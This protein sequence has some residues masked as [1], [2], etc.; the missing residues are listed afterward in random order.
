MK[1]NTPANYDNDAPSPQYIDNKVKNNEL[2]SSSTEE[3]AEIEV[4]YD[5][6]SSEYTIVSS[7]KPDETSKLLIVHSVVVV[8]KNGP[9]T[10]GSKRIT[11]ATATPKTIKRGKRLSSSDRGRT[12]AGRPQRRGRSRGSRQKSRVQSSDDETTS[13]SSLCKMKGTVQYVAP[14]AESVVTADTAATD[15][16]DSTVQKVVVTQQTVTET[17]SKPEQQ[18]QLP[19]QQSQINST[20]KSKL[21]KFMKRNINRRNEH[22]KHVKM[23]TVVEER[24]PSSSQRF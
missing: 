7:V 5:T 4:D 14:D 12:A 16:A 3:E 22:Q 20:W 2:W 23:E 1:V 24:V 17:I 10:N 9:K 15:N 18:E 8:K 13:Y 21:K 11:T 6:K 19:Q